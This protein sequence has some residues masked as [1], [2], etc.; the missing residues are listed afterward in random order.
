MYG[1]ERELIHS[2]SI[3]LNYLPRPINPHSVLRL[4]VVPLTRKLLPVVVHR[5]G[6]GDKTFLVP[7]LKGG[8]N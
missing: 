8:S 7:F 2:M 5:R 4:N 3:Y 1:V 6:W